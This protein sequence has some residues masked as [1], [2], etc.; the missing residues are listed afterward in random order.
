MRSRW[1]LVCNI[2]GL[3]LLP[4]PHLRKGLL[5]IEELRAF[6]AGLRETILASLWLTIIGF[7][8]MVIVAAK[9]KLQ[10]P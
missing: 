4:G 5:S 10:N 6:L 9:I 3:L 1:M 2:C 7:T 8:G